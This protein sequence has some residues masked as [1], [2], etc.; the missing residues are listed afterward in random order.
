MKDAYQRRR[1]KARVEK[2]RAPEAHATRQLEFAKRSSRTRPARPSC[3]PADGDGRP[4]APASISDGKKLI[5]RDAKNNPALLRASTGPTTPPSACCASRRASCATARSTAS[6]TSPPSAACPTIDLALV[7]DGIEIGKQLMAEMLAAQGA[8]TPHTG[9][10]EVGTMSAMAA[11]RKELK[12][13]E[14]KA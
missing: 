8:A 3:C 1:T 13:E 12:A 9:L 10:N 6:K 2:T 11:E 7:E 4:T 5:A 14:P